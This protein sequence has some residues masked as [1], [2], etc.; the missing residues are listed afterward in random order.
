[1]MNT[2]TKKTTTTSTRKPDTTL[3]PNHAKR[4]NIREISG[5]GWRSADFGSWMLSYPQQWETWKACG[6]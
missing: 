5:H 3:L 1:M 6:L 2:E 4:W